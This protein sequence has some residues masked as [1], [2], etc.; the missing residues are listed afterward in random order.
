[1]QYM[2][3]SVFSHFYSL[4]LS[5]F[6]SRSLSFSISHTH[7]HTHVHIL[8][9]LT[10]YLGYLTLRYVILLS[11]I[12]LCSGHKNRDKK[13]VNKMQLCL[14]CK[15]LQKEMYLSKDKSGWTHV[16]KW[17]RVYSRRKYQYAQDD[18][19]TNNSKWN[20]KQCETLNNG[21]RTKI[22]AIQPTVFNTVQYIWS[23]N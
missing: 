1:M 7:R 20:A 22:N 3:L 16:R 9:K 8:C 18:I 4:S 12:F 23:T 21:K 11:A 6:L 19:R 5:L 13:S 2:F 10:R 14:L 17:S 15:R